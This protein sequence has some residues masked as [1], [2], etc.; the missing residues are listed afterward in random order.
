MGQSVFRVQ[1]E[2]ATEV[3]R[4]LFEIS[5]LVAKRP[6]I[7]QYL[8]PLGI[9]AQGTLIR[10]DCL[11]PGLPLGLISE[12][13]GQPLIGIA[14]RHDTNSFVKLANLEVQHK[15]TRQRFQSR[16]AALHNDIFPIGENAQL[17]QRGVDLG[18]FLTKC[19]KRSSQTVGGH[20]FFD[21]L[22][23]GAQAN[24][25]AEVVEA[26]SLFFSG[27]DK[28]QAVPIIQLLPGQTHN[29]LG[30]L[31]SE[32]RKSTRLNSSHITISYAV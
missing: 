20:S 18:K 7:D 13:R 25:V 21:Q 14:T 6:A 2:S 1:S 9:D 10:I 19:R 4:R 12:C 22:L 24:Q 3:L 31:R 29:A 16:P 11:G 15:L 26:A 23:Y 17:R 30:L 28:A 8:K 32:D 5:I 27:R